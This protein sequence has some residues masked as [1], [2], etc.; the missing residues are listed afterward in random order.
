MLFRSWGKCQIHQR[1]FHQTKRGSSK[2][3]NKKRA[4]DLFSGSGAISRQLER[5]GYEVTS[6]DTDATLQPTIP[7]DI[8]KWDFKKVFP[9]GYFNLIAAGVPCTE[10]S[11]AKTVGVRDLETADAIVQRVLKII[12]YFQPKAWWIENPR[13]SMLGEHKFMAKIP[14]VDID[15]CQVSDW[16]YKKPTRFWC[17][18]QI[19]TLPSLVCDSDVCPNTVRGTGEEPPSILLEWGEQDDFF[20]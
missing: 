4:L 6:L 18:D 5:W 3:V 16:G 10:Y 17:S 15:Y 12:H 9:P 19:A 14:F 7:T 8:M 13:T 1:L 2:G 20:I 11:Q